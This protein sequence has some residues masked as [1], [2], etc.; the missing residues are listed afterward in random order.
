MNLILHK[1]ATNNAEIIS[2]V[3]TNTNIIQSNTVITNI[4]KSNQK[5]EMLLGVSNLG[6]ADMSS[7]VVEEE[8]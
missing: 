1:N 6:G 2:D 4:M 8:D 3:I 7:C 5:L